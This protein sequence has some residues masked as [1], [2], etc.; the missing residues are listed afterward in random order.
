MLHRRHI[1][2]SR[3]VLRASKHTPAFLS[4][5]INLLKQNFYYASYN[6]R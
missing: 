3:G 2:S 4:T 6:L 1:P 5:N